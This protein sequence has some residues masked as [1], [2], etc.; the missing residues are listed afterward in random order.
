MVTAQQFVKVLTLNS[1]ILLA[2]QV[3]DFHMQYSSIFLREKSLAL[4]NV[5]VQFSAVYTQC[6]LIKVVN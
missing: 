3:Q 5:K 2:H 1:L 4:P 6:V